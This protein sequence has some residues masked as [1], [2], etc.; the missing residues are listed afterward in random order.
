MGIS[1]KRRSRT[2]MRKGSMPMRPRPMWAWRSIRLPH[3]RKLSFR[4]K[5]R[6]WPSPT[7]L[8]NRRIVGLDRIRA[9]HLND[10]LRPCGSR[11]DRHAHIGRGQMGLEPFRRLLRDRRFRRVPMVL[12][13]PKGLDDDAVDWDAI[14]LRTLHSLA[15]RKAPRKRK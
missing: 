2:S 15:A 7:I 6:I 9:F 11:V 14:N 8:S 3:S 12:E 10:S 5:A 4:W 13:T 1:R